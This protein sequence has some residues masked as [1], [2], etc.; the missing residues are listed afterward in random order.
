MGDGREIRDN[1]LFRFGIP[2]AKNRERFRVL[3][4]GLGHLH[5]CANADRVGGRVGKV[6]AARADE[7][8]LQLALPAHEQFLHLL[9]RLVFV[10]LAQIA[11]AAGDGDFLGVGRNFLVHQFVVFGLAAFEAF[12]GND[13][14]GILLALLAGNQR[15]CRR[16]A[17][18]DPR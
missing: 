17:L 4:A 9:G 18:H 3:R 1:A 13:E 10:V 12:P 2:C 11:V 7:L 8:R 5:A 15:L 6:R 16:I 14:R